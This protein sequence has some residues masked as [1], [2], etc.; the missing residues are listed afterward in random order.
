MARGNNFK[1]QFMVVIFLMNGQ[2]NAL[3]CQCIDEAMQVTTGELPS[4]SMLDCCQGDAQIKKSKNRDK[5]KEMTQ[6]LVV[7][8]SKQL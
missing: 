4:P 7:Q 2:D 8:V 3:Q 5:N 1:F 6:P